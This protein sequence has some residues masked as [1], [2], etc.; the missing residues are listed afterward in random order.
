M[1]SIRI[2]AAAILGFTVLGCSQQIPESKIPSVVLNTLDVEFSN[3]AN[4]EWEKKG[5]IYEV[6]FEV[7]NIDH[8]ALIEETGT[9]IKY[10]KEVSL[11]ELPEML[12]TTLS[13][14]EELKKVDDMHLLTLGEASY[15]QLEFEGTLTSSTKVYDLEGEEMK[16]INY[17]D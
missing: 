12:K 1:K 14:K 17:Y 9:L 4:V 11:E 15:Y 10:I 8:E 6:E 13:S 7:N 5:D 3:A 16:N 2:I